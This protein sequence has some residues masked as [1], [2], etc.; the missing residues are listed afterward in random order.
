MQI[1][2][3]VLAGVVLLI[4]I[5]IVLIETVL[6]RSVGVRVFRIAPGEVER[7]APVMS[8]QGCYNLFLVAALA[9]GLF[10]PVPDIANAFLIYGLVCVIVAG[11][12]GGLT[13][14]RR[15]LYVQAL[16]AAAALAAYSLGG[17]A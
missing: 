11:L 6:F 3:Y 17:S 8:N 13:V 14:S 7:M 16:P 1:A 10:Y 5:Y 15:I 9:L 2:A 12:W 4:H